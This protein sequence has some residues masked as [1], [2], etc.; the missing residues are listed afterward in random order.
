MISVALAFYNGK[1]Y[2]EEQVNSILKNLKDDDE[3][4]ISIDDDSDGSREILRDLAQEDHRIHLIKGPGSGVVANFQNALLHCRGEI[5][6]LADQDDLWKENKAET[7]KKM[8]QNPKVTA[9]VHNAE[10]VDENL[11]S[12]GQTTFQWRDSGAGFWKNIKKNSYI[13]CCMAIRK[14]IL[15]KLLP[16]PEKV[17]IHDQWMGLLAEQLGSVVFLEDKLLLYRRHE[18]NVTGLR[19]GSLLSMINKRYH[20]VTEIKKRVRE[21]R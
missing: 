14:S 4:V 7:V 17:W 20:M 9:V 12:M 8:F 19:R 10:I 5:V 3:L 6:F 13:G 1:K 2:I 11:Q 16:I 18:Q 15:K 21:W